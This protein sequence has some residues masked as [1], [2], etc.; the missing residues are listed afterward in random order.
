MEQDAGTVKSLRDR[1]AKRQPIT[2][3]VEY[4]CLDKQGQRED[5]RMLNRW[6]DEGVVQLRGTAAMVAEF[7]KANPGVKERLEEQY[8]YLGKLTPLLGSDLGHFRLNRGALGV[9]TTL[10]NGRDFLDYCSEFGQLM[11]PNGCGNPQDVY[12][13]EHVSIHYLFARDIFITR[14]THHFR[15]EELRQ[16]FTDLVVMTPELCV[17]TLRMALG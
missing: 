17:H 9:A 8:S 2:I 11:F 14:N 6:N 7:E 1:L 15:A 13:V 3:T 5:M 4:S 12:D 16:R 10:R